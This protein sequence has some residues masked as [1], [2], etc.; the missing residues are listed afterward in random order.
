MDYNY[1][2]YIDITISEIY[3]FLL[4]IFKKEFYLILPHFFPYMYNNHY[5]FP[6][7]M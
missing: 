5:L 3:N 7:L 1:Y 6:N 2:L 4:I